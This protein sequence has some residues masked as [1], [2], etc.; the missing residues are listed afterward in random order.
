MKVSELVK[1]KNDLIE[2]Q[3]QLSID[4]VITEKIRLVENI[5]C[6]HEIKDY[7]Q[8]I[9]QYLA[10]YREL[11]S[12]TNHVYQLFDTSI[13]KIDDDIAAY[14]EH[15]TR[16]TDNQELDIHQHLSTSDDLEKIICPRISSYS[17]WRFPGLQ[18]HCRYFRPE[19]SMYPV[20]DKFANPTFRI[21]SM[22]A[23]DPLYLVGN[24]IHHLK[25]I[26]SVYNNLYQN[27]LRL[28]EIK[29]RNL[30]ALPYAQ[31][32]FI[33]CWDF[34][35]YLPIET[36]KWYLNECIRLLRPGGTLMFSYNNGDIV[37]SARL[38][39]EGRAAWATSK[40]IENII[41]EIGFE[42]IRFEDHPTNDNEDTWV[43]WVEVKKSGAL[44]TV[45]LNQAMGAVLVK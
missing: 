38:F 32:G 11:S 1:F 35:N 39:D 18:L 10:S 7:D 21:N 30:S 25:E 34:L 36:V 20:P 28:Y 31:F 26:T 44:T 12:H 6:R 3:Q 14:V 42:I 8:D 22:V 33:L 9:D 13:K 45:R 29:Q 19:H 15:H 4:D 41:K 16:S 27:R 37:S 5:R 2:I 40:S 43:S 24:D 23:N 17:D